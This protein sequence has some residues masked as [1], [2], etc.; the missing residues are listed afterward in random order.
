MPL[1]IL[2]CITILRYCIIGR[3]E[4]GNIPYAL[5]NVLALTAF[6]CALTAN[7]LA[8][9]WPAFFVFDLRSLLAAPCSPPPARRGRRASPGSVLVVGR[10]RLPRAPAPS[11]M[12]HTYPTVMHPSSPYTCMHCAMGR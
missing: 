12:A 5:Q 2:H 7:L 8:A 11:P 9:G 6:I 3:Q 1:F 4:Q 10:R